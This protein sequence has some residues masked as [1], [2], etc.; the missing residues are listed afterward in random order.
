MNAQFI[1]EVRRQLTLAKVRKALAAKRHAQQHDPEV[2]RNKILERIEQLK[3]AKKAEQIRETIRKMKLAKENARI[4]DEAEQARLDQYRGKGADRPFTPE[5]I[6]GFKLEFQRSS[7]EREFG[8]AFSRA[9]AEAAENARSKQERAE[10]KAF[11]KIEKELETQRAN[12][13]RAED[14]ARKEAA[15]KSYE[16]SRQLEKDR[17]AKLEELQTKTF[18]EEPIVRSPEQKAELAELRRM[19]ELEE[20]FTRTQDLS[21]LAMHRKDMEQA[22]SS[23]YDLAMETFCSLNKIDPQ[24]ETLGAILDEKDDGLLLAW[25]TEFGAYSQ[26]TIEELADYLAEKAA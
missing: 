11:A 25:A 14:E 3:A 15:R 16:R 7:A 5:I 9:F 17:I 2:E 8:A 21:C 26:E 18:T 23:L 4:Q 10:A 6:S 1:A 24:H 20:E 22:L 19:V 12:K 13:L